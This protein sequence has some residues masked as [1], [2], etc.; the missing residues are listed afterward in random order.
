MELLSFWGFA[1]TFGTRSL[2][3][4]PLALLGGCDSSED[5]D[6]GGFGGTGT[7]PPSEYCSVSKNTE[8]EPCIFDVECGTGHLCQQGSCAPRIDCVSATSC[9]G[10]SPACSPAGF[11]AECATKADCG[12][13][14]ACLRGECAQDCE[15]D[16]D[17]LGH[18]L[19]D[20]ALKACVQCSSDGDC[21]RSMSCKSFRCEADIC[22]PGDSHCDNAANA[23]LTCNA[24]GSREL[25]F[26]CPEG[27][28]CGESEDGAAVCSPQIC[29]PN[30]SSCAPDG[31]RLIAC[32]KTGLETSELDCSKEG[33]ACLNGACVD[34]ICKPGERTCMGASSLVEC[35]ANG[36]ELRPVETCDFS[37]YCD[38][39][40]R[41]CKPDQC[42]ALAAV[43]DGNTRTTC[44]SDGS[45]PVPGGTDCE[46]DD[47]ICVSGECREV[48]C[49][50]EYFCE[51]GDVYRCAEQ[52]TIVT[53]SD[54]CSSYEYCTPGMS[55]CQPTVCAP[56]QK[57]CEEN[58]ALECN[59]QGSGTVDAGTACDDGIC[60]DGK[61]EPL[62]CDAGTYTCSDNDILGCSYDG[63]EW[64]VID[65]C[66]EDQ[67]CLAGSTF[68][69]HD[70]C[71]AN[72]KY[73]DQNAVYTCNPEGSGST[74]PGES[75]GDRVCD[76]GVCKDRVCS[77]YHCSESGD[78]HACTPEGLY[79]YLYDDCLSNEYCVAGSS[80]CKVQ[81]CT[82]NAPM[83]NANSATTC[84]A[85]GSGPIDAGASCGDDYCEGGVCK[86][87]VCTTGYFCNGATLN[88]CHY[89]GTAIQ[90]ILTCGTN[91]YCDATSANC[92]TQTCVPNAT[93][94]SGN[95]V[96]TCSATGSGPIGTGT[97]CGIGQSCVDGE[98]EDRTCTPGT[99]RCF[100]DK[101][102]TCA[103]EG[104]RWIRSSCP[105]AKVC[106]QEFTAFCTDPWCP[107]GELFCNY[108]GP[109]I[110]NQWG[111]G[112]IDDVQ[113]PCAVD[114]AC[115]DGACMDV[116]CAGGAARCANDTTA[117]VCAWSGTEWNRYDCGPSELCIEE[118]KRCGYPV[119]I[120]GQPACGPGERVATCNAIG[121]GYTNIA[122]PCPY[123]EV[124]T[125][126]GCASE[127]TDG[128]ASPGTAAQVTQSEVAYVEY[129]TDKPRSATKVQAY[130]NSV[131][132]TTITWLIYQ[133]YYPSDPATLYYPPTTTIS[134]ATGNTLVEIP[135][136]YYLMPDTH[137]RIGIHVAG[138][139]SV[140]E[141][142]GPPVPVSLGR[143]VGSARFPFS[144]EIPDDLPM[145][146]VQSSQPAIRLTTVGVQ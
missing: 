17:C 65:S 132:G 83:C 108:G 124:C 146:T 96:M 90:S 52:G 86:P 134:D 61:C 50:G 89:P 73:C 106:V 131:P 24:A 20:P 138:G 45:G 107:P 26:F 129:R 34:V 137:F 35:S 135:G 47:K 58:V 63:T 67:Y 53:V 9:S 5:P 27:K 30:S 80:S 23:V 13:G 118:S 127:T 110:C 140:N 99:T 81:S 54:N 3:L 10:T 11:C 85:N 6:A 18:R 130:I 95:R 143:F 74:G 104:T 40:A 116:I 105:G 82:P 128:P 112:P 87:I 22:V 72:Q 93:Y 120:A 51:G 79:S 28:Y 115:I 29:E 78:V 38:T 36:T 141:V 59:S 49:E 92:K 15:Q 122:E 48:Q 109:A 12:G 69:R 121:S 25:P 91:Q 71:D 64:V 76:G 139:G 97:L 2:L 123:L 42:T 100:E 119:C 133:T 94:C 117:E 8:C 101:L 77:G 102:E 7:P 70:E 16:S 142:S 37:E 126:S 103:P 46:L 57:Y 125:L 113:T 62:I 66:D 144:G 4:A 114:E 14:G 33:G 136:S 111:S 39:D 60:R 31:A 145:A 98:C 88:Y 19:C 68:C 75:C 32:S 84:A 44:A 1:R 55:T 21:P 56:N 43:C 41:A